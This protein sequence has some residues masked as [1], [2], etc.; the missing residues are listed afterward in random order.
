MSGAATLCASLV[1]VVA[2]LSFLG[3]ALVINNFVTVDG[4]V[5][6]TAPVLYQV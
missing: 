5:A 1:A 6:S 4:L 2:C 3:F